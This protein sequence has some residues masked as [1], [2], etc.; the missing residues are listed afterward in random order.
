VDLKS[1][2]VALRVHDLVREGVL[3]EKKREYA[4]DNLGKGW[5]G[6]SELYDFIVERMMRIISLWKHKLQKS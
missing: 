5:F 6:L 4:C 2:L 1:F 3:L